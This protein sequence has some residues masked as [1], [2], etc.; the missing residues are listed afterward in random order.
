M[1]TGN[2]IHHSV[3]LTQFMV[4][5]LLL[6]GCSD[7]DS[8]GSTPG[9]MT[10]MENEP[11]AELSEFNTAS[12][13][14]VVREPGPRLPA[15]EPT[16]Q[17]SDADFAQGLPAANVQAPDELDTTLNQPPFFE[18]LNN[19]DIVAG[20][21]IELRYLPQ[22]PEGELP[23]MFPEKLPQGASFDD[24]FDGSKT[25]RWQ[26]LQMDVG[27]SRF[28]VT[29]VDP[30]NSQYRVSQPILIRVSL[31]D[32]PSSIPNVPP[33]LDELLDHTVRVNDPVVIELKGIDLN[34]SV[35]TLEIPNLPANASFNQ[36][37]RFEEIYVL[38]FVPTVTGEFSID[39]VARDS[40]DPSLSSTEAVTVN[41]LAIDAFERSGPSLRALAEQRDIKIGFAALQSF[42]H[43]PDGAIYA[44]TAAREFNIVTPEN[45]MKMDYINPEPDRYQFAATDNLIAYAQANDMTVHGHP[46]VWYRQ[47]PNWIEQAPLASL[48]NHMREF[49]NQIMSRYKDSVTIWDVINE[50]MADNG[51]LRDSIW[52]NA[53]GENY[54]D[55]ALLQARENSS[56]ATLLINEFD[57]GFGG[58]KIEGLLAL[59][60]RLQARQIPL[61]GIGFQL[62]LFS[63][64]DQFDEL[65]TNFESIAQRNLDIYITELDVSLAADDSL[66]DQAEVYRRITALCLNQVRCKAMQMWGFTDQYSFRSIFDPLPFDRAYQA[67]PAYGAL[68]DTLENPSTP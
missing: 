16:E 2:R 45:S 60:D 41:V 14:S 54:I 11:I 3:T 68:Q 34:G 15:E 1:H 48:E 29:A 23:G 43:R 27:I 10:G 55:Q 20:D 22:D 59:I 7:S 6:V 9:T 56:N 39:V 32:D 65:Q 18:N 4:L 50:P 42:Y 57:I 24:N 36:D 62:H 47:L 49:I 19:I 44:S 46:L 64:F 40:I 26:P 58:P 12:S 17:F 31:P 61:D 53:M 13:F 33:M 30:A 8:G 51:S 5:A 35:P 63:S 66:A 28:T 67:K 25:F 38:K 37:P 52:F 21:V